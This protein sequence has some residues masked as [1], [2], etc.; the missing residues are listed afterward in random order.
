MVR[1]ALSVAVKRV[2]GVAGEGGRHDPL[3]VRLVKVLIDP[4]VVK[5]AMDP[6]DGEVGKQEEERELEPIVPGRGGV[7]ELVVELT[8]ASD[9]GEHDRGR[10]ESHTRHGRVGLLHL[11]PDLVLE[12]LGMLKRLFVED[13]EV[14][15]TGKDEIVEKTE[16]PVYAHVLV[17]WSRVA[18]RKGTGGRGP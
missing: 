17:V 8:E 2:E 9:F 16:E 14:G 11:E 3:V 1:Q 12:E 15:E 6:V 10:Q 7:L 18:I 13:E 5:A 4:G